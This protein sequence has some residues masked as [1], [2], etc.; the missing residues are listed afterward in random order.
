[1]E[2]V[3]YCCFNAVQIC[4]RGKIIFNSSLRVGMLRVSCCLARG[5]TG[6]RSAQGIGEV[7]VRENRY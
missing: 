7:I 2:A 3:D 5:P 4:A 1:M 6:S